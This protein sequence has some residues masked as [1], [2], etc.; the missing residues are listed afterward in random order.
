MTIAE[1]C[2]VVQGRRRARM[3]ET[4]DEPTKALVS[5]LMLP[6][7]AATERLAPPLIGWTMS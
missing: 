7:E 4:P 5:D 3:G 1:Q 6:F 2:N